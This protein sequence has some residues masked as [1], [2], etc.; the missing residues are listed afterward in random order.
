MLL[1][2]C[3]IDKCSNPLVVATYNFVSDEFDIIWD[4]GYYDGTVGLDTGNYC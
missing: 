4:L 2:W 1:L 3:N